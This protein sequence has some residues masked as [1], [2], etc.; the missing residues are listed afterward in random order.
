LLELLLLATLLLG[1]G[2]LTLGLGE[3][4]DWLYSIEDYLSG[5]LIAVIILSTFLLLWGYFIFWETVW[6]GQTP[7]KR[8]CGIRVLRDGGF[9]ID[10]RAAF[11]R[12]IVRYA[13]FLPFFY[14]VGALTMFISKES[15]RLGDYAAGT[16]VVADARKGRP[17]KEAPAPAPAR[18]SPEYRLLGD[19]ALL[20]LR[21]LT[22]EQFAVVE[23]Y[24]ARRQELNDKVRLDLAQQIATPLFPVIGLEPP[25]G[26]YPYDDFLTELAAAYRQRVS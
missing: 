11:L 24:L 3:V 4:A 25:A 21:A 7:G 12:N 26:E 8:L 5:W 6:S 1:F 20:N 15:K 16:I 17:V 22:R 2:M 13:D 19:P 23:R 18:P 10:F 14:G 9:P